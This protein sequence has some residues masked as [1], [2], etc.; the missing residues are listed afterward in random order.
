MT[1]ALADTETVTGIVQGI[2]QKAAD[3]W[4]IEVNIGQQ[5]PAVCGRDQELVQQ[6]MGVIGQNLCSCAASRIDKRAE[7]ARALAL[8]NGYGMPGA[9]PQPAM[10]QPVQAQPPMGGGQTQGWQPLLSSP[11]HSSRL[12][13]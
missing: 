6:M 2:V 9:Q 3:K 13:A 7:P 12:R 1:V 11:S 4:Q 10:Q 8:I 5:N